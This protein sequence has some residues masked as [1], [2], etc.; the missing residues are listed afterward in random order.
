MVESRLQ[1][2]G[3][4]SD[5]ISQIGAPPQEPKINK[6]AGDVLVLAL[7]A[8]SQRAIDAIS[9]L[10]T[11]LTVA[12]VFVLWYVAPPEPSIYQLVKLGAYAAFILGV[13]LIVRRK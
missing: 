5:D 7:T 3:Q 2:V 11:L 6:I 4:E 10:F 13:N 1:L 9:R 8:L 12:S